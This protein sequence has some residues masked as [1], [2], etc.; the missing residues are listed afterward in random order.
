MPTYTVEGPD[1]RTYQIEGPEGATLEQLVA[2]IQEQGPSFRQPPAS[3]ER[4]WGE[5]PRDIAAQGLAG[6]GALVQFPGQLYGLATGDFAPTGALGAGLR[7]RERAEEMKSPGLRAREAQ[8]AERIQEAER[9]RGQFAA[10]KEAFVG[11]LT[12]PVL[13]G[14]AVIETLPALIPGVGLGVGTA[15]AVTQR[16]L[17]RGV[18]EE[19]AKQAGA[20]A[21]V[22][23]AKTAAAVQQGAEVGAQAYESLY[24]EFRRQNLS[25]QEAAERTLDAARAAGASGTIISYLAQSLPGASALERALITGERRAL[26]RAG[27]AAAGAIRETPSEMVEEGGGRATVNLA[28]REALPEQ[29]ISA[30]VGEAAGRAGAA[31]LGLGAGVG[32]LQRGPVPTAPPAPPAEPSAEG[33]PPAAPTPPTPAAP[34]PAGPVQGELFTEAEAPRAPTPEGLAANKAYYDD[35]NRQLESLT[36]QQERL[37]AETDRTTDPDALGRLRQQSAETAEQ[38][39]RVTGEMARYAPTIPSVALEPRIDAEARAEEAT[40]TGDFQ[41]MRREFDTLQRENQRLRAAYDQA[42][43]EEERAALFAEAEKLAPAL[44]TLQESMAKLRPTVPTEA[45]QRTEAPE[46]QLGLKFDDRI[47]IQDLPTFGIPM[48]GGTPAQRGVRSWLRDNVIGK[49]PVEVR[50][51]VAKDPSLLRGTGLRA[52]VLADIMAQEVAPPAFTETPRAPTPPPPSAP[53]ARPPVSEP[54]VQGELDLGGTGAGVGISRPPVAAPQPPSGAPTPPPPSGVGG[55]DTAPRPAGPGVGD[56]GAPR[57]ALAGAPTFPDIATLPGVSVGPGGRL[58]PRVIAPGKPLYRETNLEGLNDLLYT[59]QQTEVAR[60]FVTDNPDIAIGQGRNRGVQLVFR[61]NSLS[62]EERA[63]PGTGDIAGREY[64]TDLVAPKAIQTIILSTKDIPKLRATSRRALSDFDRTDLEDGR[65]RFDRKGLPVI[66]DAFAGADQ[67]RAESEQKTREAKAAETARKKQLT[68]AGKEWEQYADEATQPK[69]ADLTPEQQERW[70]KAVVDDNRPTIA[71]AEEIAPPTKPEPVTVPEWVTN[72]EKSVPGSVR[73]AFDG[74]RL[75]LFA[76]QNRLIGH[77]PVFLL[78]TETVSP[79]ELGGRSAQAAFDPADLQ[80]GYDQVTRFTAND[81]LQLQAYPDGPF[82]GATSPIVAE[83]STDPQYLNFLTDLYKRLNLDKSGARIFLTTTQPDGSF[84]DRY[85]LYGAYSRGLIV[86]GPKT[87]GYIIPFGPTNKDF[88]LAIRPG[89]SPE[90]SI[91]VMG[92]ELGHIIQHIMYDSAPQATQNAI[93]KEYDA[94]YARTVKS[95]TE[96]FIRSRM[97]PVMAAEMLAKADKKILA[98]PVTKLADF[99]YWTSFS[100]WFADQTSRWVT[101]DEKPLGVV[102]KFFA[103]VAS[104]MRKLVALLAKKETAPSPAV[105]KFLDA[106]LAGEQDSLLIAESWRPKLPGVIPPRVSPSLVDMPPVQMEQMQSTI[107]A[108]NP[109]GGSSLGMAQDA[110]TFLTKFRTRVADKAATVFEVLSK[111]FNGAVRNALNKPSLEPIYR[112]AEASDQLIP[113]YL[114][115]GSLERDRD[116]KL[117]R[118]ATKPGVAPPAEVINIVA[119]WGKR[120]KLSFEKAWEESGKIMESARQKEFQDLN[121]TMAKGRQ[122]PVSMPAA[123]IQRYYQMY[124]T[125]PTFNTVLRKIL[126]DARFDLIDNMV[127]VGRIPKEMADD[128]KTAT[129]YIPFDR[130]SDVEEFFRSGRRI[131]RGIAQLGKANP[132]LVDAE[133]V[134]RQVKNS[135]DNYFNWLGWGVRQVVQN[136]ATV[137]TI[138][139]LRKEGMARPLPGGAAQITSNNKDRVVKTYIR[140]NEVFFETSSAYHA[141]AFNLSIAPLPG[142]FTV[143][144]R[145]SQTLRTAITAIPTFTATQIPQDI[146]RAIMYSGVKD[147]AALTARTL[148]NFAEFS[149]AAVLGKLP[150]VEHE[151]GDYGVAGD[152]DFRKD[153]AAESFLKSVGAKPRTGG[154]LGELVQRLSDVARASDF[155]LRR[156]I[157]EQTLA[158]GGDKLLALHRAREIINFRRYGM[159]DQLGVVHMLTQIIPFYNAYI[160]GMD[161]LYR[162]LSGKEAASGLERKA[163]LAEF[164]KMAGYVTTVAVLYALAK[165]GDDEYE[166]AD[167]R[168]RDKTWMIDKGF[169]IPVPSELGILFKALPER[170]LEAMLKQ[171]TPD[172][173]VAGEAVVTWFRAA[174]DEYAGRGFMP[175]AIKPA[176]ENLTNYSF[177]SGRPL[178]G[179]YQQQ[180]LPSE[181]STSR[182]SE[183]AKEIARFTADTTSIQ[184]SPIKIDNFLQ[185]FFGTTAS[186]MLA[187]TDAMINPDKMDR[188]LHQMVGLSAFGYDPVGTRRAGEFYEVRDKVTQSQNTLNALIKTDLPRAAQFAEKNAETLSVY[189]MVNSTLKEIEKTRAYRNWLNTGDA[190]QSMTQKERADALEGVKRY[191]QQLFEWVRY[192]KTQIKI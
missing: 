150:Q 189:K 66:A 46:G 174:F 73:V 67:A 6:L 109:T 133:T 188:P 22:A 3:T 149:K 47:Q 48:D 51:L 18:S 40:R 113:A 39:S 180:L 159:G 173:A 146:Q 15:R 30:G 142:I 190:A 118:A 44:R 185:G 132:Q 57:G 32:A 125:D 134:D 42:T 151:L 29:P 76:Y 10:G 166:N 25:E 161:V 33:A 178:E 86:A 104:K 184:I 122:F 148:S 49:T 140:G 177:L 136:D 71:L 12:D 154:K 96:E 172:E 128:W 103:A 147:K 162:A 181:R 120:N 152:F 108:M 93:I 62:G 112:Q 87:G 102:E 83:D 90:A 137:R 121:A 59:D 23:A 168:E 80:Y 191:E 56:E 45:A 141:A 55:L 165:S 75:V 144:S 17:A 95:T 176:I 72:A 158:E 27:A 117:W 81:Q 186:L 163:A 100:E 26:G 64:E 167:L 61:P 131:G 175:A 54:P 94:W 69:W 70:R 99:K 135:L 139:A 157:Y 123:D 28:M 41:S 179:T 160:Q 53:A 98:G 79:R 89:Q 36:R 52:R 13:L 130:V 7:M 110:T 111:D 4:T 38:I 107:T 129:A 19:A 31:A 84:R 82:T 156:A 16:A 88:I 164:Y 65:T 126:D 97:P 127:K 21:G 182:T 155:A 124:S 115:K 24:N 116:T 11:T 58:T 34:T 63:K 192:A 138:L 9:A 77:V 92:H 91:A 119:D 35:L 20:A 85:K 106:M 187:T 171:G 37:R 101:T 183:L 68:R 43:T 78:S 5:V 170:I 143:L 145:I 169:G 60:I 105:K 74:N 8:L 1:K 2:V 153:D 114:R 14:G 50:Q